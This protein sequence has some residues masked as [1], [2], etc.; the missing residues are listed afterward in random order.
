M[1]FVRKGRPSKEP[2]VWEDYSN[3][4]KEHKVADWYIE[5]CKRIKYMFPKGHAVA[6]VMMAMRIAYFKVH[7]PLAFYAAYLSR[8]ADDFDSDFMLT[9]D[10]VKEKIE[11]L[12]KEIKLDVRQKSQMAVSEIILEMHARGFEFLGIDVYNSA[13]YKFT[14][15]DGKIRVP[16]VALN[17]LGGAVVENV[18]HEREVGKFLSYEDLKRR[19][20]ASQT[21]IEKL[22]EVNAID[23]LSDTNQKSLF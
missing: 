17:G 13:G 23:G 9:L 20:K 1:E 7:Y 19:T 15:E 10:G 8:K 5:S 12:G 2:E 6:Y 3:L 16:L 18:I 21:V 4:M 11:E 14:L 22:K